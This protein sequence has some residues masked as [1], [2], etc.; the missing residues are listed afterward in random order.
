VPRRRAGRGPAPPPAGDD[1][2]ALV[3]PA[4]G[5]AVDGVVAVAVEPARTGRPVAAVRLEW[6]REGAW[7]PVA[8]VDERTYE[9]DLPGGAAV[10]RAPGVA[11]AGGAPDETRPR[12]SA[13]R[14]WADRRRVDLTLDTRLLPSGPVEL[15]A[16]T[17]DE[18]GASTP[19]PPVEV[20]VARAEPD[21]GEPDPLEPS[22]PP[23]RLGR[24]ARRSRTVLEAAIDSHPELDDGRR[25]SL[26]ALLRFLM[27][28]AAPDG[29]LPARFDALVD[30]EF[31]DLLEGL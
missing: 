23:K 13:L 31:G 17:V 30:D 14:P 16:V 20:T 29:T 2:G 27:L 24:H 25:E 8:E 4:A 7:L 6:R 10:V 5:A 9:L 18:D 19:T 12:A 11:G 26:E 21:P 28:Y 15:R 22:D 1:P 3:S